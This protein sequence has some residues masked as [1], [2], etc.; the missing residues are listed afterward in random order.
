MPERIAFIGLGIMGRP[1]ALNLLKAG[2]AVTVWN[3]TAAKMKPLTD[4]GAKPAR[5]AADAASASTVTITMVSDTPDVEEVILG[6]GGALDGA[7]RTSVIVD[8]S[9]ISPSATRR[10]AQ[11][12]AAKGVEML[13]A[14]VSGGEGGAIAGTLSIMVG[15]KKETFERA[16]PV[17]EAMGKTITYCGPSGSGQAAK[18]CNQVIGALNILAMCEG[19]VLGV[20]QGLDPSTLL[21]AVGAGAAGSWMLSNLGPKIIARNLAPG[22]M[23]KLQQKDLRLVM[24]ATRE[25]GATL[26]GATL[27]HQLFGVVEA[28][29]GGDLGTQSLITVVERL[30]GIAPPG[31][32]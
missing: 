21:Q 17:F 24:E 10:I 14:P 6:A 18:L 28:T 4:A 11:A 9:T 13:D 26:P 31:G 23:V 2:F 20:K 15:G 1:M 8:M 16:R 32:K 29:G 5:S 7:A 3:R 30:A 27:V 25:L 19:L 22:F 12:C